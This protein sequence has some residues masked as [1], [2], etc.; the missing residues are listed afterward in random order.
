MEFQCIESEKK[1]DQKKKKTTNKLLA[2]SHM[3]VL[4][5]L[6]QTLLV[7]MKSKI[8][9]YASSTT[10]YSILTF[11]SLLSPTTSNSASIYSLARFFLHPQPVA[12]PLFSLLSS[13]FFTNFQFRVS[14]HSSSHHHFLTLFYLPN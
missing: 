14:V 9:I 4:Q 2:I 3:K 10:F 8:H 11:S 6:T 5:C 1:L 7:W 12:P 13:Y